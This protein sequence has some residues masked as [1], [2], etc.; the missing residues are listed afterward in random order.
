MKRTECEK[1]L[2]A[3]KG[4]TKAMA[5]EIRELQ[6]ELDEMIEVAELQ[7]NDD[8][9]KIIYELKENLSEE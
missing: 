4:E 7:N 8:S 6:K 1:E 2:V 9:D 5:K 3:A